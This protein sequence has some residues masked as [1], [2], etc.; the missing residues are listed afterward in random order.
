MPAAATSS[1]SRWS[2]SATTRC[3]SCLDG[4]VPGLPDAAVRPILERAD[5]VPLYAVETVRMLVARGPTRAADGVYRP[6]GDLTELAVPE[7]LQALIAARLDAPRSGRPGAAPGAAVLGQSF[8]LAGAGRRVRAGAARRSSRAA[9]SRPARDPRLERRPAV[10]GARAVR[11]RPGAHPRGRL[12]DPVATD[13]RT[14]HLAAARYFEAS[15]TTRWPASSPTHYLAAY[16]APRGPRRPSG[17]DPGTH[18]PEGR[19]RSCGCARL[20]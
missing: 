15:A 17:R 12:R 4:L 18:C 2:R 11:L 8:T 7:T 10:A 9:R 19:R 16:R 20:A 13:R 1:R 5:G 14:R 3:A 6:V